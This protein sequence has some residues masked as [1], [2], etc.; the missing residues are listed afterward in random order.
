V[1]LAAPE[2][3]VVPAPELPVVPAAAHRQPRRTM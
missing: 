2:L 1:V 3:P